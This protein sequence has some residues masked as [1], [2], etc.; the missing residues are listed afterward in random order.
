MF[1]VNT[2]KETKFKP[3][4]LRMEVVGKYDRFVMNYLKKTKR[5]KTLE[6]FQKGLE[7]KQ[8][9]GTL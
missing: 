1:S 3:A 5:L 7:R 6:E 9:K 2:N 8:K 4:L